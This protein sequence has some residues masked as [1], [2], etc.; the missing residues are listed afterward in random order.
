MR[1]SATIEGAVR[2][3]NATATVTEHIAT[4]TFENQ[5]TLFAEG[6]FDSKSEH[7][8]DYPLILQ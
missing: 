3:I 4:G 5:R 6:R 8:I 1:K 7:E 2:V